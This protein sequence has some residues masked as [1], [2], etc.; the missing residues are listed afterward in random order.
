MISISVIIPVYNVSV[1]VFECC[2]KSLQAQSFSDFEII[3]IDDGSSGDYSDQYKLIC[4]G[5][6]NVVYV[7]QDNC[8]VSAA[9]NN[10][11]SI[12]IGQYI[13]Y[14][15]ADDV[16][17]P[18]YLSDAFDIAVHNNADFVIG[19]IIEFS[20]CIPIFEKLLSEGEIIEYS[21]N[22]TML[23]QYMMGYKK[24]KFKSGRIDQGPWARLIKASLNRKYQ[25]DKK[26]KI[27]ED[28]VWNLQIIANANKICLAER[29]WYGYH[30][31]I[32][33]STRKYRENA[34]EE[35]KESL[36]SMLM[37]IDLNDDEQYMAFCRRC[38]GDLR[39]I[40]KCLLQYLPKRNRRMGEILR[41]LYTQ[42][43]WSFIAKHR[44]FLLCEKQEKKSYFLYI[45][46]LLFNYWRIRD[47]V[48]G[49]L[50]NDE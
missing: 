27:G 45:T 49:M 1:E 19:G 2:I 30:V 20:T 34:I 29:V 36:N 46:K 25:F 10:G 6:S 32:G 9:R 26:L 28:I 8:G 47:Y 38:I 35:S 11:L 33:S 39:R 21:N 44:F 7:R 23:I 12:A 5:Y 42:E 15:D 24:Y 40:Y 31:N 14:V 43:P 17:F 48:R 3:V 13:A 18:N 22:R 4:N 37:L 41:Q 50:W 16:V